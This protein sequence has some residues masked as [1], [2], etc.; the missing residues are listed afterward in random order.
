MKELIRSDDSL[1]EHMRV[2]SQYTPES[3]TKIN[4][5]FGNRYIPLENVESMLEALYTHYEVVIP[6]P[7]Q[8]IDNQLITVV[9]LIVHHPTT[10]KKL[11]YSGMSCVSFDSSSIKAN[12]KNIPAGESFAIMNASR[13]I[14]NIFNPDRMDNVE[15]FNEEVID[16]E[17]VRM[18]GLLENCSSK[19]DLEMF[20]PKIKTMD[21]AA[22]YKVY[23]QKKSSL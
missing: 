5:S 1:E 4:S 13:K 7:P 22:V 20:L 3:W 17:S 18:I 12:H 11:T 10:E 8:H 23:N 2:L 9:N 21:S 16:E 6:F 15:V 19:S 14:G